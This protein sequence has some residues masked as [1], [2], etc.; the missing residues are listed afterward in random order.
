MAQLLARATWSLAHGTINGTCRLASHS[1]HNYWHVCHLASRSRHKYWHMCH[2]ASG[3]RHN[4][5]HMSPA[6]SL[7]AQ[8]PAHVSTRP[9][10]S[11]FPDFSLLN[12][13]PGLHLTSSDNI[14]DEIY[15]SSMGWT[16]DI[17]TRLWRRNIFRKSIQETVMGA[18]TT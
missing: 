17:H 2:L 9:C 11:T 6:L 7:M 15:D 3:S 13:R 5:W 4:Y 12:N 1:W 10:Y 16:G 8:L 18:K 14:R